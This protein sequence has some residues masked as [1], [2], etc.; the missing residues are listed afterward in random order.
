MEWQTASFFALPLEMMVG[1]GYN[2]PY[3]GISFKDREEM[4][5]YEK[6]D[7]EFDSSSNRIGS[8]WSV[9]LCNASGH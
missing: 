1:R 4:V 3:A 9:L 7:A 6:M 2:E 5:Y 8:G